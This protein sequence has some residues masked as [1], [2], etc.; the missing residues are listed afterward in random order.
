MWSPPA[1]G[2]D[3]SIDFHG[4]LESLEVDTLLVF[5]EEDSWCSPAVARRMYSALG[6]RVGK[7]SRYISL[8]NCGHCP[9]HES[10]MAV[11]SVLLPWVMA[12]CKSEIF[13]AS[14]DENEIVEPWGS[15][16][17]REVSLD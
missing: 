2:S 15:V 10:P 17:V 16:Y 3:G 9:N 12:A 11:A 8:G 1:S 13:L 5:G 7:V 4:A 14:E 6:K